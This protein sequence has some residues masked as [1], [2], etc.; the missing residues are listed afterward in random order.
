MAL[1]G[2]HV[3]TDKSLN[4]FLHKKV[5]EKAQ[6]K[7]PHDIKLQ[8]MYMTGFEDAYC[9]FNEW[10]NVKKRLPDCNP[11]KMYTILIKSNDSISTYE[12]FRVLFKV[13]YCKILMT[14]VLAIDEKPNKLTDTIYNLV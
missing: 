10:V 12:I 14:A 3:D 6:K 4:E 5:L 8:A 13:I 1:F 2:V 11:D 7:Y 9:E